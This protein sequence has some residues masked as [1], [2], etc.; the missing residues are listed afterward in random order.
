MNIDTEKY[1]VVLPDATH[2]GTFRVVSDPLTKEEA[3][4]YVQEYYGADSEGRVFLIT[5]IS[6]SERAPEIELLDP[7]ASE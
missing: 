5:P 2:P 4:A 1:E 7:M 6:G 3:L